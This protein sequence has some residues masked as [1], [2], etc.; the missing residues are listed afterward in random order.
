MATL[1]TLNLDELEAHTFKIHGFM[2]HGIQIL[3]MTLRERLGLG[4]KSTLLGS[5][6]S[7]HIPDPSLNDQLCDLE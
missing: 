4:E 5:L 7:G 6:S 2:T 3:G 1:V